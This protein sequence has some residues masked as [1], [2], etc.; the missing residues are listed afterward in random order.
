MGNAIKNVS[1]FVEFTYSSYK[2]D[3]GLQTECFSLTNNFLWS[4]QIRLSLS[5]IKLAN[6]LFF[7]YWKCMLSHWRHYDFIS[8]SIS[9][10]ETNTK[11]THIEK[12]LWKTFPKFFLWDEYPFL[13]KPVELKKSKFF[14]AKTKKSVGKLF[15]KIHLKIEVTGENCN[16][17]PELVWN[18]VC[19]LMAACYTVPWQIDSISVNSKLSSYYS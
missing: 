9:S 7:N 2:N 15:S 1:F 4:A 19:N 16:F 10:K 18:F 13:S 3:Q 5:K 14:Y 8:S 11:C 6:F 17:C 12:L